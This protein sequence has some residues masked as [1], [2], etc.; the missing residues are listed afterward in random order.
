M[1]IT[2]AGKSTL[3]LQLAST[4]ACSERTSSVVYMSGEETKEQIATRAQ[5]LELGMENLFLICNGDVD[6][7]VSEI[8]C[9]QPL[10]DLLIVD[11]VQTMYSSTCPGGVGSVTQIRDCTSTFVRFAK[12]LGCAVVLT[13]HVTKSGEVAGPRLLEHMVD[14]VLYLEGSERADYRLLRGIKNRFGSTSEMG[15]FTMEPNG[16]EDVNN[17]SE[18]FM[19]PAVV[20]EGVEGAAV[21]VLME[22][23]RPLLAEVQCLVGEYSPLK[24]PRRTSDG[25]PLQRLQLIC[26]VL[27]KRLGISLSS[28]EVYLNV[29]GGLKISDP[30]SDLAVAVTIISSYSGSKLA[31]LLL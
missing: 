24:I 19:S 17:P 5:R 11:S 27:E 16:L 3:L 23:T 26:A 13:G 4:I 28:R 14:T 20:S 22:G 21:L 1:D 12:S 10:P 30:D 31:L 9:M 25:F 6:S 15:V 18:L 7:A 29:V 8:A 2:S